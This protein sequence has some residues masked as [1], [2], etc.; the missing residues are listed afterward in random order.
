M[1][2]R[3]TK[4]T[5]L[6]IL[7]VIAA[8]SGGGKTSLVNQLLKTD[9]QLKLSI[10]HTTRPKRPGEIEGKHYFFVTPDVFHQMVERGEFLE[11]ATV[12]GDAKGTTSQQVLQS[13][14]EGLDVIL[15][16]DWQGARQIRQL[17]E[18]VVS[19]FILP[20]SYEILA[21]RLSQRGQDNADIIHQRMEKARNEISHCK[22]F[23]FIVFNDD[24][25]RCLQQIQSI[26]ASQRLSYQQQCWRSAQRLVY[27][28][29]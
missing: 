20:P 16:I 24:F 3:A 6:G 18:N 28:D 21:E 17:F 14:Q 13:L 27:L 29:L 7:F 1:S 23:D 11:H 9:S 10:S 12:F 5:T 15:E 19:I 4:Q 26:I 2:K 25:D 8:P 22:E